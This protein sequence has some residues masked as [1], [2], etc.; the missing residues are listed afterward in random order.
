MGI[1]TL[2]D[3][4][5]FAISNFALS[6]LLARW[7]GAADY[8]AFSVAYSLFLVAGNVHTGLLTEPLLVLGSSKPPAEQGGYI[9]LVVVGHWHLGLALGVLGIA[10]G[11]VLLLLGSSAAVPMIALGLA[12][13]CI[14]YQWL[15]R[16]ACY[17]RLQP[18]LAVSGG[19]VYLSLVLAGAFGIR[20][21]IGL[22][23]ASAFALMGVASLVAGAWM[24]RGLAAR[25]PA[26]DRRRR[27]ALAAREHW[28]YGRWAVAAGFLA[29]VP[30]NA[31]YLLLPFWGGLE[32]TAS[33]RSLMNL[34]LPLTHGFAAL[35][36]L[37]TPLFVRLRDGPGFRR[38]VLVACMGCS[39]AAAAC[40]LLLATRGAWLMD[41][42]Y[43]G[44]YVEHAPLLWIVGAL[45]MA[46]GATALLGAALRALERPDRLF[47]AFAAAT[48][49]TATAGVLL[50]SSSGIGGAAVGRLLAA[51]SVPLVAA[52]ALERALAERVAAAGVAS[53]MGAAD[54]PRSAPQTAR[55]AERETAP[56]GLERAGGAA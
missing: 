6:L 37:A 45:P 15:L 31:F 7:L 44:R 55:A 36:L 20:A 53:V 43:D 51:V 22:S 24:A 19:V 41:V 32:A 26:D 3:Q 40:W 54:E 39:A 5:L 48:V 9:G 52:W 34:I 56:G 2:F 46:Y 1:A 50:V 33:L 17:V 14:L 8:G 12:G 38:L 16:R 11:G 21:T 47:W 23:A 42:L 27:L 25:P 10:A 29:W 13:P 28:G 30:A 35:G 18:G 4:G 49:V